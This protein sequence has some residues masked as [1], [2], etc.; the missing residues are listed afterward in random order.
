MGDSWRG[1]WGWVTG[2]LLFKVREGPLFL[3]DGGMRNTEK[4]KI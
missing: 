2:A 1:G 3:L 4:K